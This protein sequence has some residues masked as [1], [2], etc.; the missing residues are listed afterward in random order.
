[1]ADQPPPEQSR[2]YL[3]STVKLVG[4][5][6]V[7]GVVGVVISAMQRA[8]SPKP[9]APSVTRVI[10]PLVTA[11]PATDEDAAVSAFGFSV[12]D[13]PAIHR[14]VFFGSVDG[15]AQTW[16]WDG[17]RWDRAV[18]RVSPP[19]RFHAASAYD[20]ATGLV[21]LFGGRL[22]SGRLVND[23][24][25]WTGTTWRELDTG[26]GGPPAGESA[27]MAWDGASRTMVLVTPTGA[28]TGGRT[29]TWRGTHW[30]PQ[31][32]A[33][34]PATPIAAQ[35]AFDPVSGA[36]LL[37][38]PLLPPIGPG[39]ST[40]RYD[41]VTW[42]QLP[43]TPP[44][45]TSGVTVDPASGHLVVCSDP[46]PAGPTQLWSWNGVRWMPVPRSALPV[47][48]GVEVSDPDRNEVVMLGFAV[49]P[50]QQSPQPVRVWG[51]TGRAWQGLD[52]GA[53]Q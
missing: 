9:M 39:I 7:A 11:S 1:M 35:M 48:L 25:A 4:L 38:S 47:E 50:T 21:M 43:A 36:M 2:G 30:S 33:D 37:V 5:I 51:W 12:S 24:W 17:S 31:R 26:T 40:W 34:L 28:I 20:P 3:A 53:T 42:Q 16:L 44:S 6:A 46:T 32:G 41:G 13:D 15:D 27:L 8:P 23:T 14:V 49:S 45:V 10:P 29:W 19:A 18:S 22:E 52:T